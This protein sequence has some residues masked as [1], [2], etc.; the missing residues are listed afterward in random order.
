MAG[1]KRAPIEIGLTAAIVAV[2]KATP[3]ILVAG[4]GDG[5]GPIGLPSGP[6]DPVAHRTFEIALRTFVAEQ[7]ALSVGY[8]EQLYTFGDRGRHARAE[9]ADPHV[10]SV[11]YLALTRL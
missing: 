11:G 7:T 8:V 2:D 4:G 5:G 10:L 1:S 6:F 3:Q 9:D